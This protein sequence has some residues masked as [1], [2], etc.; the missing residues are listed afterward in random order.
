MRPNSNLTK[1]F[2]NDDLRYDFQNDLDNPQ[3]FGVNIM[4]KCFESI[5]T[6]F[7]KRLTLIKPPLETLVQQIESKPDITGLKK[8]LAVKKSVVQ[9][10]QDVEIV[11]KALKDLSTELDTLNTMKLMTNTDDTD[12]LEEFLDF[13]LSDIEEIEGDVSMVIE[14]MDETD[15]FVSSHQDNVRNELMKLS[16]VMEMIAVAL[17]FGAVIGGIMGMNVKNHYEESNWAFMIVCIGMFVLMFLIIGGFYIKYYYLK[18]D[19]SKAQSFNVL[20]NFF[21]CIDD[22]EF[23]KFEKLISKDDFIDAVKKVT[24]MP[25]AD[26]E[27][28]F[29]FQLLDCDGDGVIDTEKELVL[30]GRTPRKVVKKENENDNEDQHHSVVYLKP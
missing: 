11:H 3:T 28:D 12:D 17:A 27:A 10:Q 9:F 8:L 25:I 7:R 22:L 15:Q 20:Q 24:K 19:T 4:E 30:G 26:K 2:V 1:K 13:L 16:L 29:L 21:K 14:M 6:K 23:F 18:R 5:F